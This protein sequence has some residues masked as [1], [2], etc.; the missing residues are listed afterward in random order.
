M[1]TFGGKEKDACSKRYGF[2][3][4]VLGLLMKDILHH[5]NGT[6]LVKPGEVHVS[7]GTAYYFWP[8]TGGC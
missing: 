3:L 2:S 1:A 4:A 5:L 7:N 6:R 8:E